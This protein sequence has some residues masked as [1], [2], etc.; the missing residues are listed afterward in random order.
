MFLS[1]RLLGASLGV[2]GLAATLHA[3]KAVTVT[4]WEQQ[5]KDLR[6]VSE[7]DKGIIA[8]WVNPDESGSSIGIQN[9]DFDGRARWGAEGLS[10]GSHTTKARGLRVI[11]D[12]RGG[13]VAAWQDISGTGESRLWL[14]GI[15]Q[16]GKLRWPAPGLQVGSSAS[17]LSPMAMDIDDQGRIYLGWSERREGKN[18]VLCQLILPN[19]AL[20]W[21][22]GARILGPADPGLPTPLLAGDGEGGFFTA[23]NGTASG[24][25]ALAAQYLAP[26]GKVL[27]GEAGKVLSAQP[28]TAVLKSLVYTADKEVFIVWKRTTPSG[29]LWMAQAFD[30]GGHKRWTEEGIVLNAREGQDAIHVAADPSG[31]I[32]MGWEDAGQK[33]RKIYAQQWDRRGVPLWDYGSGARVSEEPRGEQKSPW[34]VLDGQG[35]FLIWLGSADHPWEVYAQRM[36]AG[37][38]PDWGLGKLATPA[39]SFPQWPMAVTDYTGGLVVFWLQPTPSHEWELQARRLNRWGSAVW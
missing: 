34:T 35:A 29:D 6:I 30:S 31:K 13:A 25:P 3:G 21:D 22:A 7:R 23:W 14:Q 12:R 38:K 33:P 1:S 16:S 20:K 10:L 15:S 5:P 11:A 8:A 4:R 19:K 28:G 2:I 18:V 9:V 39:G 36:T 26:N 27:W 32:L 37:G 17:P 24:Q